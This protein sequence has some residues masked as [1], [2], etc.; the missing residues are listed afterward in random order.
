MLRVF[1]TGNKEAE[2]QCHNKS[3]G[4]SKLVKVIGHLDD[5]R[6]ELD[7]E[8]VVKK[9]KEKNILLEINNSSLKPDSFRPNARENY[10]LLLTLCKEHNVRIILG[11][12]APYVIKLEYLMMQS[13]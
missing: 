9:A 10:K 3:H 1:K 11:S 4:A 6:Y 5:G 2:Y 13:D 7:Y 8:V 12:D